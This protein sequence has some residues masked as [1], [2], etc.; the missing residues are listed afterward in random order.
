MRERVKL[1]LSL[2]YCTVESVESVL[3]SVEPTFKPT[4]S[5][6]RAY[7][8]TSRHRAY[9]EASSLDTIRNWS[10]E[11]LYEHRGCVEVRRG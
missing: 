11:S 3:G 8:C 7:S 10:M 1:K 4:A 2:L 6:R 9:V 5:R